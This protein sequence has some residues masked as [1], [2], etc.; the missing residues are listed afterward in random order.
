MEPNIKLGT[1]FGIEIGVNYSWFI[2][3]CLITFTFWE[4]FSSQHA[5]WPDYVSVVAA[6]AASA[7]FFFSILGHELSHSLIALWNKLPVK[8]ITLFIFGG[9]ST[10][11]KDATSAAMEFWV[12]IVGPLSSLLIAGAFRGISLL[13][14]QASPLGAVT[15]SLALVNLMLAIFNLVPGFPLDGGRVL[16]AAVWFLSG[17]AQTGTRIAATLG[18][19][20][21]YGLIVLGLTSAFVFRNYLLNGLWV[22]VIGW[23]LVSAAR[24]SRRP[25]LFEEAVKGVQARDVMRSDA[26][27]VPAGI[28]L[29]EFFDDHL[30][31]TGRRSFIVSDEGMLLGLITADELKYIDRSRWPA[32]TVGQ[33]MKPFDTMR[34]VAPNAEL[35]RVLDLMERDGVSQ[36]PV[37]SDGHLE[38]LI[39]RD[40]L[41][42]FAQTRSEFAR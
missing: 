10:I 42:R 2:I 20:I 1:L 40:D 19:I 6:F 30:I 28:S 32:L 34:W 39:G 11:E 35:E 29:Q 13:A 3:F 31:R 4:I 8:S 17:S 26:A 18:Q 23:F 9:V 37:V 22:A 27:F 16:R 15:Y 38:G 25:V 5:L 21:G 7:L 12:A 14:D 24:A 36:V 41:L 33:A